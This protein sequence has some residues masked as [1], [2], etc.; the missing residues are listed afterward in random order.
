MEWITIFFKKSTEKYFGLAFVRFFDYLSLHF[1]Q[2]V[3]DK[4]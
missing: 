1:M 4:P 2:L 3:Y